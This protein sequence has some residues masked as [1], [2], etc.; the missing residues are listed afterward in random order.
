[1]CIFRFDIGYDYIAYY[2]ILQ[3]EDI[4]QIERFEF[5]NKLIF[6]SLLPLKCPPLVFI[7]YGVITLHL[8]FKAICDNCSSV[9]V[10]VLVFLA[11]FLTVILGII[12]QGMSIAILLYCYRYLKN[13]QWIK[14]EIGVIIAFLFHS[15]AIVAAIIPVIYACFDLKK[16]VVFGTLFAV[17]Y[18]SAIK[19]IGDNFKYEAYL[20]K[21]LDG[22]NMLKFLN[23][24]IVIILLFLSRR[25]KHEKFYPLLYVVFIGTLFPFMFGGHLGIRV[26]HYFVIYECILIPNIISGYGRNIRNIA[27]SF[28]CAC[29]IYSIY[30]STKSTKPYMTPYQTIFS[31]DLKNPPFK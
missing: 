8:I 20:V 17:F 5:L 29:F 2:N 25:M 23:L 22:G 21:D 6:Y 18:M 24:A 9:F 27:I 26:S 13:R 15:S 19:L 4:G 12:R 30:A 28:L 1:V 11:F 31:V 16:T 10:G 3:D 7:V 14:Y